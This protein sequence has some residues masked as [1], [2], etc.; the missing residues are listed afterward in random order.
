MQRTFGS[1]VGLEE[2]VPSRPHP[3]DI[4]ECS[5][6]SI[7]ER[8]DTFDDCRGNPHSNES[9]RDEADIEIVEEILNVH[10]KWIEEYCTENTDYTEGYDHIVFEVLHDWPPVVEEWIKDTYGD[11]TKFDGCM[12]DLV[13]AVCD[14][15]YDSMEGEWKY[16]SNEYASYSSSGC[17]IWG[18]DIGEYEE[19]IDIS[20]FPELQRLY[21]LGRL[22]DILESVNCD[23]YVN[24]SSI[25]W[26]R[27]DFEEQ[28]DYPTFCTSHCPGGRWDFVVSDDR[29]R[30]AVTNG[31]IA[32]CRK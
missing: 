29:M 6:G 5:D 23:A 28:R 20:D 24:S 15:L 14:D 27:R 12:K 30:E 2:I 1:T 4:V 18:F 13:K 22:P 26:L 21:N 16:N 3:S 31:I 17:C 19:Q 10:D 9:D 8:Q 25:K 11:H 32:L 7:R